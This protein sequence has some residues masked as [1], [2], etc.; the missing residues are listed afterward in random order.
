MNVFEFETNLSN[1][2]IAHFKNSIKL[3]K[4][5]YWIA[6][7][8]II[9]AGLTGYYEGVLSFKLGLSL[10]MNTM[11]A[12]FNI[13]EEISNKN[14]IKFHTNKLAIYLPLQKQYK[15]YMNELHNRDTKA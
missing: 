10:G 4:V 5:L 13:I 2:L 3:N 8:L 9:I 14:K 1:D 11:V 15:D 7:I 6:F 12:I